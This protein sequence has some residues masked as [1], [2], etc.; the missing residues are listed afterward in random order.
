LADNAGEVATAGLEASPIWETLRTVITQRWRGTS[1]ELRRSLTS[2]L[3]DGAKPDGWPKNPRG[4]SAELK[5]LAPNLRAAG[6]TV[7]PPP[8]ES[9]SARLWRLVPPG[10]QE[11]AQIAQTARH[12][13]SGTDAGHLH[14]QVAGQPNTADRPL[15]PMTAHGN[16][17]DSAGVGDPGGL[18]GSST[19]SRR[20]RAGLTPTQQENTP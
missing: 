8:A 13:Q 19:P 10:V 11:T 6:W 16:P 15:P 9:H 7:T 12:Q 17:A 1:D 5:R 4:L 20:E 2:A 14:A 3:V 18:G